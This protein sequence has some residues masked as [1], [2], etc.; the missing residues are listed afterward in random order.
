MTV[1]KSEDILRK[2]KFSNPVLQSLL[3][4]VVRQLGYMGVGHTTVDGTKWKILVVREDM[5][6]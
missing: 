4:E 2:K 3:K 5:D 6:D 1:S